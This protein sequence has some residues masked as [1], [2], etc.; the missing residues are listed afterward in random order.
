LPN[1]PCL[2]SDK[3]KPCLDT[4]ILL[5]YSKE[6]FESLDNIHLFGYVLGELDNLKKNGKTEEVKFQ[7]RRATRDIEKYKDKITYIIDETDYNNL[8]SYFDKD[9]MDN[10]IIALLK[11]LHD[12][13]DGFYSISN[14][15]LFRAKCKSLNIP[16]E[17]F[18]NESYGQIYKGY[19]ELSGDTKFINDFFLDIDNG[20]NKYGFVINEYL[21]MYNSDA[22]KTDEYRFNGKKFIGLKLPDSKIIKGKNSLQRC[23][24]DLLNNKE[25]PIC[26]ING[27]VGSGK[28]YLCVRMGLHQTVDKGDFNKLLAIREAIGEGK[29]V[30]YLKG[31][32]EEK[33][34]MFFKP[35][36]HSLEGGEREL[37][38]L[39]SRGVLESNIPFY[40][41]GTTYDETVIVVDESSDFSQKQLKLVGTR[42]GDKSKIY[43]AGDYKQSCI[44]SSENN[45]LV[46]MCNELKGK[47]EFGCVYLEEDVRS[48]ASSIFSDLFE[49]K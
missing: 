8:P 44:D 40:L 17:K 2:D 45:A 23:A 49:K 29:E 38:V 34:S 21:I 31:T 42:L 22:K 39:L 24:L 3:S 33:T 25:I 12:K 26:A 27:K 7:A 43:F 30:G 4:N 19:Q 9:V 6:V 1:K 16:C 20:I 18:G 28:T 36:V 47:K 48:V 35:I 14:D 46:Q 10:K 41:K 13:D 32:F 37:E 15:L 11:E 5:P